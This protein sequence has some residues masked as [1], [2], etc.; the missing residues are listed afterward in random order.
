MG[1]AEHRQDRLELLRRV[2][3]ATQSDDPTVRLEG[4]IARR[5]R[6]RLRAFQHEV[7]VHGR[8]VGEI[9]VELETAIIEVASGKGRRKF[10][11]IQRLQQN[12]DLNPTGKPVVVFGPQ[13]RRG[14]V[15]QL[16]EI[17]ARV[18]HTFNELEAWVGQ[19]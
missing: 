19:P 18:V 13:M 7:R 4:R 2:R 14:L 8:L 16:E 17:G 1:A 5:L 3:Q 9:D 11:Q 6:R 10:Q 15:R 12:R